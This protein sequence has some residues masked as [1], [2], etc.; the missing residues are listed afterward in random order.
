MMSVKKLW[1]ERKLRIAGIAVVIGYHVVHGVI[2]MERL[3]AL[4]SRKRL[5]LGIATGVPNVAF[6]PRPT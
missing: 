1:D 6:R 2:G 5:A 3:F 4:A